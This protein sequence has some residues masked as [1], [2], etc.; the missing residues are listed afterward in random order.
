MPP[1][2][3]RG[4]L[5]RLDRARVVVALDLERDGE[6]VA[7]RDHAGVLARARRPRPRPPV[8]SVLSSGLRALVRAVLAPH[9]AEH[10]ELEVVGVAPAEPVADGVELLVGDAEPAMERLDGR[11][12]TVIAAAV[13]PATPVR[14]AR[15]DPVAARRALDERADDPDPVVRAQDRLRGPLR[16]RHQAGD[17]AGRVD[18]ARRSPAASRWGSRRGRP[19]PPRRRPRR[20]SGTGPAPSRSSA[21]S[22]ASSA[23]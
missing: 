2:A 22:V 6:A 16:V 14:R 18:H 1:D 8:G 19:R 11:S 17:V 13:A 5:V 10:R 23:K 21:S 3:G 20:R 15:S 9:D 7:D 12:A 4:A